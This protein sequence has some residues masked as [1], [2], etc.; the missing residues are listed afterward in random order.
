MLAH[1]RTRA[2]SFL[3]LMFLVL[4][5]QWISKFVQ[6][7]FDQFI[8][9]IY[10]DDERKNREKVIFDV[11]SITD[12]LT[13]EHLMF[14][15]NEQN[16]QIVIIF[17]YSIFAKRNELKA[18]KTWRR[19]KKSYSN[20]MIQES[21][22][23]L[24]HSWESDLFDA[25]DIVLYDE[26]H[27]LKSLTIKSAIIVQWLDV[28]FHVL[29]TV[30]SMSN[31][32]DD[33]V[34]Y[35]FFIESKEANSW[36]SSQS[37]E[38]MRIDENVN[39]FDLSHDHSAVKLRL[40]IKATNEWIF[41]YRVSSVIKDLYIEFIFEKVL[42]RRTNSFRISFNDD[43]RI[44]DSIS[45][46]RAVLINCIHIVVEAER[47][48]ALENVLIDQL[49]V[50]DSRSNAQKKS[51][52]S[53]RIHHQLQ[54]LSMSLDLSRLDEIH[55]LK[56]E[57]MKVIFETSKFHLSWLKTLDLNENWVTSRSNDLTSQ[58]TK[59]LDDASKIR[60]LIKNVRNQIRELLLAE[61]F[62]L[63]LL[64]KTSCFLLSKNYLVQVKTCADAD[65]LADH[66]WQRKDAHL[67]STSRDHRSHLRN[68]QTIEYRSRCAH[69]ISI[70]QEASETY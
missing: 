27:S 24:N 58:L 15:D 5:A 7:A 61:D 18:L 12:T 26:V 28:K 69:D 60:A 29:I 31:D 59:L 47:H 8:I 9:Y 49:I 34:E 42:L 37:L 43:R 21:E 51:K 22:I 25:F 10:Y 6:I 56:T 70:K 13:R 36:W 35:M 62:M 54:L 30:T 52:W 19:N 68:S 66:T 41:H 48:R 67:L 20:K 45:A 14:N 16:A 2:K 32:I 38:F 11:K 33:W 40:T 64:L 17:A 53:L 65:R 46:V 3:I 55:N 63:F 44:D 23:K 1:L 39:S 4:I 57:N 50:L